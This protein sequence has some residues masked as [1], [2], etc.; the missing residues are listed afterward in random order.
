MFRV[1]CDY[2][3][4]YDGHYDNRPDYFDYD[5]PGD[6]DSYPDVYGFIGPDDYELY[7]DLHGPDD[8]GVYCV[9]RGDT[10]VAPYWTGNEEVDVYGGD[11]ALPWAGSDKPVNSVVHT[12]G[13]DGPGGPYEET[14]DV[15]ESDV[16]ATTAFHHT[17][18]HTGYRTVALGCDPVV[19]VV[20]GVLSRSSTPCYDLAD[21]DMFSSPVSP[22]SSVPADMLTDTSRFM[23]LSPQCSPVSAEVV[24]L[25]IHRS[26]TLL[27]SVRI[28][29]RL[30]AGSRHSTPRCYRYL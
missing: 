20:A 17:G 18:F 16:A 27:S 13:P 11:V 14:G 21:F 9:S 28:C 26:S 8:C 10:G 7:H 2:D 6:F 19:P 29:Q 5:D 22:V 4:F 25:W 23:P 15:C 24:N 30:R 12:S 3:Y 1:V